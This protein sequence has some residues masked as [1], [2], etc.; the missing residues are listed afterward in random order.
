MI[1]AGDKQS[2]HFDAPYSSNNVMMGHAPSRKA[3]N[4]FENAADSFEP[5][6]SPVES[7]GGRQ[8]EREVVMT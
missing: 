8:P 1:A 3:Q 7:A 4:I 5:L 2:L 6:V